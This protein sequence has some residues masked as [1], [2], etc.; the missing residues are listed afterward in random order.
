[1]PPKTWACAA[2]ASLDGKPIAESSRMLLA[3]AT[4]AENSGMVWNADRTSVGRNWG[5]APVI[6]QGVPASVLLPG[7]ARPMV[8]ALDP[9]GE[10]A[11]TVSV[12]RAIDRWGFEVDPGNRSIWYAVERPETKK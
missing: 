7:D 8:T 9:K 6:A 5:H 10:R 12:K 3:I 1:M 4:R 2:I 11:G